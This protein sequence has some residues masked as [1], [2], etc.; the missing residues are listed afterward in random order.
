MATRSD[1]PVWLDHTQHGKTYP[2]N[3][4]HPTVE[5]HSFPARPAPAGRQGAPA[6]SFQ[7]Y[8]HYSHHCF[9]ISLSAAGHCADMEIYED[10]GR[11]EERIFDVARW[12]LS[13]SLPAIIKKI[14]AKQI[15]CYQTRHRNFV[16]VDVGIASPDVYRIYF[17][18]EKWP[19]GAAIFVE[20]AYPSDKN[21][22]KPLKQGS[23]HQHKSIN[24][25]LAEAMK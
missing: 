11:K 17:S 16:V 14:L 25:V 22:L 9:S 23:G 21:P 5:N 4:L 2:I 19:G 20:S 7:V 12:N 3:H 8:V 18:T 10:L 1:G 24:A 15:F 6:V 13:K